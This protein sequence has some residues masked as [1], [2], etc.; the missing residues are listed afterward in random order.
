MGFKGITVNTE[1]SAPAHIL[2]E[3]DAAIYQ[4]IFGSDGVLNIGSKL[5]ATVLSNNSV[6]VAD[7]VVVANGHI[8]RNAYA[9][10]QDMTIE[11]GTSGQK[12]NDLIVARFTTTGAG[13]IDT[14]VLAVK[15]GTAGSSASDPALTQQDIY[16]GGKQREVAL[17]RVKLDGL[18]ITGVD[19]MFKVIPTLSELNIA[20]N[21]FYPVGSI[22]MSTVNKNPSEYFGGTWVAWCS[23]RVPIGVDASDDSFSSAEKTGGAKFINLE[24]SHTVDSHTH[25]LDNDS[26]CA[27][28]GRTSSAINTISYKNAGT[29]NSPTYDRELS[30]APGIAGVSKKATDT[31]KLQGNT[32]SSAPG[33]NSKLSDSQSILPPY[34]TCYMWKRTA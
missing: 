5:K 2:A 34:I 3:D 33:T 14:F 6:R 19:Q 18:S 22:Y 9:D 30:I 7:G 20:L 26:A 13:G 23:G 24:H 4:G 21:K 28:V 31:T 32:S 15:K 17:Y 29:R 10:Y 8:G 16:A 12:R 27:L 1:A 25:S 11:N